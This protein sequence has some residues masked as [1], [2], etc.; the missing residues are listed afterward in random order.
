MQ[1]QATMHHGIYPWNEPRRK[2]RTTENPVFYGGDT[3]EQIALCLDCHMPHCINCFETRRSTYKP[4]TARAQRMC[5]LR[6]RFMELW[7]KGLSRQE[8][9]KEMDISESAYYR[10]KRELIDKK[11][12]QKV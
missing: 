3:K 5:R 7:G 8:F 4:R 9:C 12:E 10:F 1:A 6:E 2:P 11:G